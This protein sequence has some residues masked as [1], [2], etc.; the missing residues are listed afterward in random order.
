VAAAAVAAFP[1]DAV[2]PACVSVCILFGAAAAD[3]N[4]YLRIE[5]FAVFWLIFNVVQERAC[6]I[7]NPDKICSLGKLYDDYNIPKKR[8]ITSLKYVNQAGSSTPLNIY[9]R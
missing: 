8:F 5:R 3:A 2:L 9:M 7:G 1:I 6:N 4:I